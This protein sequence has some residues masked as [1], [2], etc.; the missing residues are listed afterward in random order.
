MIG[1]SHMA[2]ERTSSL[3]AA[4]YLALCMLVCKLATC[5]R[6]N[7]RA[8]GTL[9]GTAPSHDVKGSCHFLFKFL[10]GGKLELLQHFCG[11]VAL[12]EQFAL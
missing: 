2:R 6:S 1:T 8:A 12:E 7:Q 3:S 11:Q 4:A 10:E 9:L 5:R